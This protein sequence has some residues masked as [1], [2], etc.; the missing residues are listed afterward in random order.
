ML[1]IKTQ[2]I[3]FVFICLFTLDNFATAEPILRGPISLEVPI[4]KLVSMKSRVAVGYVS[5][6]N[7]GEYKDTLLKAKVEFA[8]TAEIHKMTMDNGI[9][10]MRKITGG[11][12]VQPGKSVSL[13]KGGLHLM[14]MG[15]KH[16]L[17]PGVEFPVDLHFENQG[18]VQ[19]GF[20][21]E[22]LHKMDGQRHLHNSSS[23]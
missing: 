12:I 7:N 5:I 8:S 1:K 16:K 20:L 9:M 18:W 2:F 4:I 6:S 15:L 23:Q 21:V 14:F 3:L 11:V 19:I 10:R 13:E 22:Q 17:I